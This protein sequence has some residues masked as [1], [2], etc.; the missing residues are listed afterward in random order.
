MAKRVR[1]RRIF[2][3]AL[4][5]AQVAEATGMTIRE[6]RQAILNMQLP[7]YRKPG[8]VKARQLVLVE[9]VVRFVRLH[10]ERV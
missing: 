4:A 5:P 6:V 8:N 1:S 3:I 7:A 9:D 10:L 2:P